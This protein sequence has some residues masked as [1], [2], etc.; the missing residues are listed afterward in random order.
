MKHLSKLFRNRNTEVTTLD[1]PI[2]N[3]LME[4]IDEAT[5]KIFKSNAIELLNEPLTN[6]VA[7][8]W[9]VPTVKSQPT[10]TQRQID[11]T[12]R[13]MIRKI[14]DALETEELTGA[15]DY[16]ID[17]LIKRLAISEIVF[18]I[19]CYKLN[20]LALEQFKSID[21]H[22]LADIQVAGHA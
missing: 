14:Q 5:K 12:I 11:H 16:V 15:K 10:S 17:Y 6:V 7:A 20:L 21:T 3:G 8:V 4:Q 13:P 9:G 1:M 2:I 22:N 18:M 19:Q